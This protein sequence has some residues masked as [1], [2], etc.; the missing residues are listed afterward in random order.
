MRVFLFVEY[1]FSLATIA[2]AATPEEWRSQSIYFVLTDRF[3]RT[4]NSTSA[5]CDTSARVGRLFLLFIIS[6]FSWSS[7]QHRGDSY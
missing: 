6:L 7:S 1:L 2:T 4:D 3:A 5:P